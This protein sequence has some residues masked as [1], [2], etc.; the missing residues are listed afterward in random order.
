MN[1]IMFRSSFCNFS[2][3]LLQQNL[4]QGK[5]IFS[6][7]T[8]VHSHQLI[9]FHFSVLKLRS[10]SISSGVKNE[11]VNDVSKPYLNVTSTLPCGQPTSAT[12]PHLLKDGEV[13]CAYIIPYNVT[14]E[15]LV[16]ID[17]YII[18][19]QFFSVII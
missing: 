5:Y 1:K 9:I 8:S 15:F 19:I 3:N 18:I 13:S 11:A 16:D 12:H 7:H 14:K 4:I 17:K 2:S 10:A 6:K